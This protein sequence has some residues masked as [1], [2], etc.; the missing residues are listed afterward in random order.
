M[1]L[2][3]PEIRKQFPG[4]ARQAIFLT[5]P[6]APKFPAKASSVCRII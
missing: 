4:L 5:A 2:N 3:I 1:A 6:A